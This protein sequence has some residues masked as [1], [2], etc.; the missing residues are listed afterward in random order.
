MKAAGWYGILF[1]LLAVLSTASADA[2]PRRIVSMG[3]CT[4]QLVMLLADPNTILSVHWVTQDVEDSAMWRQAARYTP[5]HGLAEE[6][7]RLRP[8]MVF[9]DGSN[10]PLAVTMLQRQGISVY[11]VPVADS[12]AGV[13]A[14]IREIATALDD[15]ARGEALIGSFD[16]ALAKTRGSLAD[17]RYRSL[18]YGANGFSAGIPSLFN[19]VLAHLG[20]VNIAAR[21]GQSGWVSMSVEEVL[22]AEP[23]LLI[24]GE[25]RM[26][27]P[28][29]ANLVL[30]HPALDTLRRDRPV[31]SVP[32]ALWNCGTP[33]LA[34]AAQTL[35]DQVRPLAMSR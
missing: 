27:A 20:L 18:V 26:D 31:V 33:Y 11:T 12:F 9:A 1:G 17:L 21:P 32:T 35:R 5:N 34:Q 8:D 24:L 29:M 25:Y 30:E 3:L 19:D 28:S 22:R 16:A 13:R 2:A 23:Q 4:D 15:P 10:S 7:L 6:V 14:N